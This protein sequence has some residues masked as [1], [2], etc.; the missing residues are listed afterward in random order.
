MKKIRVNGIEVEGKVSA[1]L[2]ADIDNDPS[3]LIVRGAL[4]TEVYFDEINKIETEKFRVEGINVY[5]EHFGSDDE[6]IVYE[7]LADDLIVKQ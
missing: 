1:T 2:G 5:A 7:F 4:K 6:E 3:V